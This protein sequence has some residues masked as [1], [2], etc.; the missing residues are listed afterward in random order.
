MNA[1]ICPLGIETGSPLLKDCPDILCP[2]YKGCKE[3]NEKKRKEVKRKK[4]N[5]GKQILKLWAEQELRKEKRKK[6]EEGK[7][8]KS[9]KTGDEKILDAIEMFMSSHLVNVDLEKVW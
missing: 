7:K 4:M 9:T 3:W 6:E 2:I 5:E 8:K 1:I